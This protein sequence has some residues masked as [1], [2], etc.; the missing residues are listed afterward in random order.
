MRQAEEALYFVLGVLAVGALAALVA[1]LTAGRRKR[2][3][4]RH[5]KDKLKRRPKIDL[6]E[7]P[8]AASPLPPEAQ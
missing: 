7:T 4:H 3:R 8:P 2:R 6:F 1:I 5:A